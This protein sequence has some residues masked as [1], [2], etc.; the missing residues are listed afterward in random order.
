MPFDF[1][2]YSSLLLPL[3]L[4]G[5]IFAILLM[6]RGVREDRLADKLLAILVFLV[7]LRPAA[8]MLGFAGW[9]NTHDD[10]TTFMF[11][12][13]FN[14]FMAL[15]PL[16][17]FYFLSVTN[18]DFKFESKHLLHF[19]PMVLTKLE[20]AIAYGYDIVWLHWIKGNPLT[21]HHGT[22]G[23]LIDTGWPV[24]NLIWEFAVPLSVIFYTIATLK[25]YQKYR[26][27]LG[28]AFSDVQP[29]KLSWLR[30]FIIAF[31]TMMVVFWIFRLTSEFLTDGLSYISQW[32]S[33]FG[34]GVIIYYVSIAGYYNRSEAINQL[35]FEP[36]QA[37]ELA[38]MSPTLP[39]ELIVSEQELTEFLDEHKSYLQP[40]LTLKELAKEM[41][42]PSGQ[43]SRSIN[44]LFGQNFND[45]INRYRVEYVQ[46]AMLDPN[47]A[48]LSLLGIAFESG[49]NSKATFNRVFK[50][51]TGLSPSAYVKEQQEKSVSVKNP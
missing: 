8:W 19:I 35:Q 47:Y 34:W 30:N 20:R 5:F 16:I 45:F 41:D 37:P 10:Y 31:V 24:L 26:L 2:L 17:Y 6:V 14:W 49:F 12:F 18:R 38:P 3:V 36:D 40:G 23:E 1:N 32:Y 7:T 22:R 44:S 13:P 46:R 50:N 4:Q 15:G 39:E 28:T 21:G 33:Y 11:Y 43:L 29:V 48:H 9:Y 25:L 42:V 27:Y 51:H